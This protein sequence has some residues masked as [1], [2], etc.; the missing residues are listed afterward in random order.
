MGEA[1]PATCTY[2]PLSEPYATALREAC[3]PPIRLCRWAGDEFAAL[4]VDTDEASPVT[5]AG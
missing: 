3:P 2:P 1:G 5:D 4:L